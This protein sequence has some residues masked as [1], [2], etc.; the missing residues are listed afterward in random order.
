MRERLAIALLAGALV[1]CQREQP[2]L[3]YHAVGCGTGDSYDVPVAQF[4][5]ELDAALAAG[6]TFVPL[7]VLNPKGGS[8]APLPA[9][10]LGVSFDDGAQCLFSQAFPELLSRHVPF[11]LFLPARWLDLPHVQE[12]NASTH[13][14]TLTV[15]QVREMLDSNLVQIGAHGLTHVRLPALDAAQARAEIADSAILLGAWFGPRP[16]FFA[17][18]FGAFGS[19]EVALV[20]EAGYAGAFAVGVGT[21]GRYAYRRRSIHAGLAREAFLQQLDSR[22]VFPLVSHP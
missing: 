22:W 11:T 15:P 12:V 16:L 10:P 8:T 21:G 9:K 2:V 14:A 20:K 13:W 17:Y 7:S 3:L 5:D 19:R 6:F 1:G 4:R 18:P